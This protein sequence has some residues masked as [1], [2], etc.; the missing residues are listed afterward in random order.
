MNR[1]LLLV[2]ILI[3]LVFMSPFFT[4]QAAT[5]V[6]ITLQPAV[7]QYKTGDLISI[8]MR[9]NT[10]GEGIYSL[11][12]DISFPTDQ[13]EVLSID[14]TNSIFPLQVINTY[15]PGKISLIRGS[16]SPINTVNGLIATIQMKALK[17]GNAELVFDPTTV[18]LNQTGT[19]Q[20]NA[21]GVTL[22]INSLVPSPTP[23]PSPTLTPSPLPSLLPSLA[24]SPSI[25]PSAFVT[26][27]PLPSVI[28]TPSPSVTPSPSPSV[29]PTTSTITVF[30]AGTPAD[31]LYP[32]LAL[33]IRNAKN[34]WKTVKTFTNVT[35]LLN[36]LVYR[37]NTLLQPQ[38]IRVRF[39]NDRYLPKKGQDRNLY[40]DKIN[41]DGVDIETER[42]TTFSTGSW[43]SQ[44]GCSDGFKRSEWLHCNGYFEFR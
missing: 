36:Q 4:V 24:P 1:L 26:P 41:L 5:P 11:Q 12:T 22:T 43:S 3:S 35:S 29:S 33:Q 38:D 6:T 25:K 9:I 15:S 39:T 18:A 17:T 8:P 7:T 19:N 10:Q 31:G 34:N 40:I 23:K 16:F 32:T 2:P 13:L 28:P 30:A 20:S 37:H 42:N 27:S 44:N 14:T 21:F